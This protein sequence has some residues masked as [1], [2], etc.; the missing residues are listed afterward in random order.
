MATP[1]C[2]NKRNKVW[3][4][5]SAAL[6]D[7]GRRRTLNEDAVFHRS[8]RTQSGESAGLYLV[9]D[10]LG[11][12]MAG[13]VASR[14]AVETVT[15]ELSDLLFSASQ[16]PCSTGLGLRRAIETA[17]ITAHAEI[18]RYA[19]THPLEAANLGTTIA[20]ALIYGDMVQIAN[21][22][23]S[24][25]YAWRAGQVNQ[26]TQ[27]HSWAAELARMG[28]I[29]QN[30]LANHPWSRVLSQALGADEEIA[31]DLFEWQLEPGDKLLLCSDGFWQAF[32]ETEDLAWWLGLEESAFELCWRLVLE[33]NRRDG[34]DNISAVV[35]TV[36]ESMER[37]DRMMRAGPASLH[38]QIAA[39]PWPEGR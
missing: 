26:I 3:Q 35:V 38:R 6:A 9:C 27:D 30:E 7:R 5:N 16:P 21:V 11:G 1:L 37:Q 17:I 29:G 39:A 22:G 25:V 8:G 19:Q 15:A 31:V 10:G 36:D 18:Q 32:P 13:E 28:Q 23:D 24:R 12:H 2:T 20:L 14:L 33:A 34:S 4:I